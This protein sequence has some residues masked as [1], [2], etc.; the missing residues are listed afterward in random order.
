MRELFEIPESKCTSLPSYVNWGN[1]SV[2]VVIDGSL[3]LYTDKIK[4]CDLIG[5]NFCANHL[6]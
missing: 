2:N 6:A 3:L 1:A 4:L 5:V